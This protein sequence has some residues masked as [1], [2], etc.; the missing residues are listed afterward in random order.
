M[1]HLKWLFLLAV[2]G[3]GDDTATGTPVT[4]PMPRDEIESCDGVDND[5]D[6]RIDEGLLRRSCNTACGSGTEV[7]SNG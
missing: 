2:I 3:C 5:N 6:T 7:C 4:M 1:K